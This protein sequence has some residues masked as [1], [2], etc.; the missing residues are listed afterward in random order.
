MRVPAFRLAEEIKLREINYKLHEGLWCKYDLSAI[1]LDFHTWTSVK[2]LNDDASGFSNEINELPN[3][4][5]GLYLFYIKCPVISGIT[6]FPFYVGRAQLTEG[7]NLR[8]RCK[9]YYSKFANGNERPKITRM[10][11]YW[12]KCLHL[13]FKVIDE[14]ENIIDYE[15]KL[16]NS[17]LLPMNDEIPETEIKQAIKAFQ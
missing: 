14:N 13:A 12:G 1:N 17:L 6:E 15:K 9:E 2:Y 7:Q 10:I 4:R 8:K 16:I 5:G 3:D 11:E